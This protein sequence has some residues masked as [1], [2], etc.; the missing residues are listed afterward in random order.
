MSQPTASATSTASPAGGAGL[1][2]GLV[3]A[4]ATL[5]VALLAL[6]IFG[7]LVWLAVRAFVTSWSYPNLGP[8]GWTLDWWGK[9]FAD[10]QLSN[11]VYNSFSF[12]L[13][14]V[15]ASAVICLPAA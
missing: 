2:R 8:D 10:D 6:F 4:A 15:A 12:A 11:A 5:V 7:P 9:V 13:M 3:G 1:R 14:T